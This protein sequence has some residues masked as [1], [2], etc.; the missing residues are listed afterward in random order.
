M[1]DGTVIKGNYLTVL[2]SAC[3]GAGV[4]SFAAFSLFVSTPYSDSS[5]ANRP[6]SSDWGSENGV[7]GGNLTSTTGR[8]A[9]A[10]DRSEVPRE[11]PKNQ[12]DPDEAEGG[13][14]FEESAVVRSSDYSN[15]PPAGADLIEADPVLYVD[16]LPKRLGQEPK[17][18][19]DRA[20]SAD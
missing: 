8:T 14:R 9:P 5:Y 17:N 11:A 10:L 19:G 16:R 18:Y 2:L 1:A 20:I 15:A 12:S 13:S 7:P 6:A 3:I 4:G